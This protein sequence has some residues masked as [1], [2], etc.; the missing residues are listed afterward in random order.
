MAKTNKKLKKIQTKVRANRKKM[1]EGTVKG[2]PR[3]GKSKRA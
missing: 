3:K 2:T 1:Q